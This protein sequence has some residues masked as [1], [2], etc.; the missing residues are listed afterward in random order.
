MSNIVIRR[1]SVTEIEQSTTLPELLAEYG[2]ESS[3]PELGPS[4]PCMETYRQM[5]AS[6]V[7]HAVGA[8]SPELVGIATILIFGIPHYSGRRIASMES[9]FVAP[10]A[11]GGGT[12]IKLLRAAEQCAL[13]H[14]AT[15]LM[16]SAPVGSRLAAVM[17]RSSYRQT[18]Q[19]FT[20]GLK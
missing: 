12:G 9:F 2:R 14:G 19:V 1:C 20:K 18:N 6:G 3:I 7:L 10:E 11:R 17:S 5:A 8:F 15:A 13:D 4:A 16:V